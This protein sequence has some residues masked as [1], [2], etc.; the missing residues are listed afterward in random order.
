MNTK[1]CAYPA[2]LDML[3]Y[4]K[5]E[6]IDPDAKVSTWMFRLVGVICHSTCDGIGEGKYKSYVMKEVKK[7]KTER[8]M[9]KLILV[10]KTEII[11]D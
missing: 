9:R 10:D 2:E 1:A 11:S 3:P 4:L 7:N 8:Y 6:N 5:P